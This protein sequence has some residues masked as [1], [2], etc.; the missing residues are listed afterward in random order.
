MIGKNGITLRD[1]TRHIG[2]TPKVVRTP[3]IE[4]STVKQVRQYLRSVNEERKQF[5]RTIGR[6]IHR[7]I[8]GRDEANKDATKKIN[9]FVS[10]PSA[11]VAKSAEPHFCS[12][13]DSRVLIDCGEKPDNSNGTPYLYVPQI[14]PLAHL[15]A[16]VLTHAHLDHCALAPSSTSTGMRARSTRLPRPG[17]FLQCSSWITSM[18]STRKSRKIPCRLKR[19]QDLHPAFDHLKLRERDGYRPG[20]QTHLPQCRPYTRIRDSPLP[21][22]RRPVQHALPATSTTARA[23]F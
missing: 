12:L 8:P 1:I 10:L 15:D 6:R 2:W 11:V 3:P 18:L 14:H 21:S 13:P 17:T 4:S 19:G 9:E 16:V 23:G 20:Y 5:L 7:D 22:R